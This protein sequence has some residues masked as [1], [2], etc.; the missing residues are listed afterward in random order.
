VLVE[1][2]FY[3]FE[4]PIRYMYVAVV[5]MAK[6]LFCFDLQEYKLYLVLIS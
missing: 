1:D 2:I 6:L 3:L 5:L 4:G